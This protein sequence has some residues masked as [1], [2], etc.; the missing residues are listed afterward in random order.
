[1]TR[2]NTW[3]EWNEWIEGLLAPSCPCAA[4]AHPVSTKDR[5]DP[6]DPRP[7]T[8]DSAVVAKTNGKGLFGVP[9]GPA[10]F[11]KKMPGVVVSHAEVRRSSIVATRRRGAPGGVLTPDGDVLVVPP[12]AVPR[13]SNLETAGFPEVSPATFAPA[14]LTPRSHDKT[15]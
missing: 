5:K 4:E 14:N 3:N 12:R 10:R 6:K 2:W 13:I 1:M 7:F 9:D 15:W 8:P 11:G